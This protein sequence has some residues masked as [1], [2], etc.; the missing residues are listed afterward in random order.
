MMV[1]LGLEVYIDSSTPNFTFIG[2]GMGYAVLSGR[3]FVNG[4]PYTIRPLSVLSVCLSVLFSLSVLSLT[5]VYC[6]QP[7]GWIKV[8]LGMQVGLDPGHTVDPAP[9]PKGAQ[10]PIF[11]LYLL[12]PNGWMDQ[13]ATWYGGRPRP[14]R[15]CVR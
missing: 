3:P 2:T 9:L 11:G 15:H 7:V 6:G 10:P 5:L 8:N 1:K 14:K 12:W 4:S 13:D